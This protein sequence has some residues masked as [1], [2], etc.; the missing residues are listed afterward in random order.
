MVRAGRLVLEEIE[1]CVRRREDFAFETT[2]S[3]RTYVP[4]IRS[5]RTSGYRVHVFYLWIPN[6]EMALA[7]IRDR[8]EG[9]GHDVPATDVRRRYRRT[10]RNLFLLY[11]REL[12]SLHFFDNSI[13]DPRLVFHEDRG[14]TAVVDQDLYHRLIVS[15]GEKE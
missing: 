11:R 3:G 10:L 7:R 9:G 1:A 15:A 14:R 8:V 6:T 4:L 5:I 13:P 12:D 2:L